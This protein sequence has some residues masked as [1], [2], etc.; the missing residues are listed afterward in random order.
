MSSSAQAAVRGS[1]P[2]GSEIVPIPKPQ[3]EGRLI[4]ALAPAWRCHAVGPEILDRIRAGETD[5]ALMLERLELLP[6]S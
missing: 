2:E 4:K 5:Q 1:P 3:R 6:A